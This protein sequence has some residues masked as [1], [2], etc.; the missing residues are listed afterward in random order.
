VKRSPWLLL[1]ISAYAIVM[2]AVTILR[3]LQAG[4]DDGS[5]AEE[6]AIGVVMLAT[7]VGG[8]VLGESILARRR[9][10]V[11]LA[12]ERRTVQ[13][14]LRAAEGRQRDAQTF[15]RRFARDRA[16]QLDKMARDRARYT[17]AHRVASAHMKGES[18]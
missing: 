11:A 6:L 7:T 18:S 15:V 4:N 13:R 8:A 5:R 12:K 16:T 10:S 14:R 1:T 3:T 2:I 9:P 17:A